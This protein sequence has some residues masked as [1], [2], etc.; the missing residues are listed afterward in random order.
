[1][2]VE[3]EIRLERF[4]AMNNAITLGTREGLLEAG[5]KIVNLAAQLAPKETEALS[6]SGKVAMDNQGKVSISFGENLPDNR[7]PAQEFGTAEMAAQP[8]LMPAVRNIDI[9]Q[10][11]ATAIIKRL[12]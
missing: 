2:P 10:E 12:S 11:I 7:A 6:K 1:M 4:F 9:A 8:Y 5:K 3:L